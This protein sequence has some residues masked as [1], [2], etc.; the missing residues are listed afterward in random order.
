MLEDFDP[1]AQYKKEPAILEGET[2]L[3]LSESDHPVRFL[4]DFSFFA[5]S[6]DHLRA[7]GLARPK[8]AD[9]E[10]SDDEEFGVEDLTTPV[11]LGAIRDCV[12]EQ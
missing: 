12:K 10:E 4:S 9:E 8:L 7:V 11:K 5:D 1:P 2:P 3:D 6:T